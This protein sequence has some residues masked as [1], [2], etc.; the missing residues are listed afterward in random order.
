MQYIWNAILKAAGS[1]V[2]LLAIVCMV[3]IAVSTGYAVIQKGPSFAF[4]LLLLIPLLA[5]IFIS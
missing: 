4:L 1:L 3:L 5:I 2:A